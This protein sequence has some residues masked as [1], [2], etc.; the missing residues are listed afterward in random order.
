MNAKPTDTSESELEEPKNPDLRMAMIKMLK[1]SEDS[2]EDSDETDYGLRDLQLLED[3][4]NGFE[5]HPDETV[6][7]PFLQVSI[8]RMIH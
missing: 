1:A 8:K 4:S 7:R 5:V 3:C 6:K 2:M